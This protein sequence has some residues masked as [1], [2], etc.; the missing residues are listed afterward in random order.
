MRE[1]SNVKL[2]VIYM[3]QKKEINLQEFNQEPNFLL[4]LKISPVLLAD[5][6]NPSLKV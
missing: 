3:N 5:P 1:N 4:F 6:L 2:V